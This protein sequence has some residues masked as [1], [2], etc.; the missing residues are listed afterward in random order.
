MYI[1]LPVLRSENKILWSF[2]SIIGDKY[3]YIALCL[4]AGLFWSYIYA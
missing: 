3:M 4:H 2:F 1:K